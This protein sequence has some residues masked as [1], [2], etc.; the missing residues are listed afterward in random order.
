MSMSCPPFPL[1]FFTS[2]SIGHVLLT[3]SRGHKIHTATRGEIWKR[4]GYQNVGA[5]NYNSRAQKIHFYGGV[6][7]M[8]SVGRPLISHVCFVVA[9]GWVVCVFNYEQLAGEK[10]VSLQLPVFH[11]SFFKLICSQ[12][13]IE[14]IAITNYP[15]FE[16]KSLW[17]DFSINAVRVF[18]PCGYLLFYTYVYMLFISGIGPCLSHWLSDNLYQF[19]PL[20]VSQLVFLFVSAA[21]LWTMG[22]LFKQIWPQ[23]RPV[24]FKWVALPF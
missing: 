20:T 24:A 1:K 6:Y 16:L 5:I 19:G 17:V 9:A 2:E 12:N 3:S 13:P 10:F 15:Q 22:C 4:Y 21:Y 7:L 23:F 11:F 18:P 14:W 8:W